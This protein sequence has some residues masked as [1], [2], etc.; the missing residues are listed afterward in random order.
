MT[1]RQET[2]DE[3]VG[4]LSSGISREIEKAEF[5]QETKIVSVLPLH[6]EA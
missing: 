6:L 3:P 2:L 5:R 4:C 1:G